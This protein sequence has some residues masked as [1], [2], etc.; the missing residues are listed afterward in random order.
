MLTT[1]VF[2]VV[3]MFLPLF[4]VIIVADVGLMCCWCYHSC[5]FLV[6]DVPLFVVADV[7][8]VACC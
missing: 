2:A 5:L 1:V 6:A 7:I 4:L 8:I 3:G